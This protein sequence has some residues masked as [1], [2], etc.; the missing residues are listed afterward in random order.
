MKWVVSYPNYQILGFQFATDHGIPYEMDLLFLVYH[1]DT[2]LHA[3][4]DVQE[5]QLVACINITPRIVEFDEKI[6][7]LI[8]KF[9]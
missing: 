8:Y 3:R 6:N 5:T 9:K 4:W 1:M 7:I 2:T